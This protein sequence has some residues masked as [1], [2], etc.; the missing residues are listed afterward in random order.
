MRKFPEIRHLLLRGTCP[1]AIGSGRGGGERDCFGK[2]VL[3]LPSEQANLFFFVGTCTLSVPFSCH[4]GWPQGGFFGDPS[5]WG[6]C[7]GNVN[8]GVIHPEDY[9]GGLLFGKGMSLANAKFG[10]MFGQSTRSEVSA[11]IPIYEDRCNS[12]GSAQR[13]VV[14]SLPFGVWDLVLRR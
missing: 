4:G 10:A 5:F 2:H 14:S 12:W 1:I 11:G 7:P 8:P 13:R 3:L 6:L 9:K